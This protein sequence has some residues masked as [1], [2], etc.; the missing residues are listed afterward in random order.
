M[1]KA[2][3]DITGKMNLE[4]N[5]LFFHID[6][7]AENLGAYSEKQ[8]E[9]FHLDIHDFEGRCQG[10]WNVNMLANYRWLLNRE[11]KE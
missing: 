7:F 6:Y 3:W 4:D 2:C 10:K 5:F 1:Y 8:G 9:R 11:T